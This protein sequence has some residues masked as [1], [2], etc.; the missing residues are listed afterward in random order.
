MTSQMQTET[1]TVWEQHRYGGP[2]SVTLARRPVPAP[3]PD[4][5][6][7]RVRATALNSGDVRIMRGQPYLVRAA[8]GLR[9]PRQPV[10]GM[11]VAG[12][13]VA[14]G[15]KAT[16]IEIGD[17]V[18]AEAPAGGALAAFVTV[19]AARV[20]PRP[21]SVEPA[22]AAT[23]PVAGGTA[24]QALDA[25]GVQA[26]ASVLVLGAS[27]GVGT[28]TVQLATQRGAEVWAFCGARS[29]G[30]V[31]NLGAVR[32]FDYRQTDLTSLRTGAFDAVIDIA[33]TAPLRVLRDLLAPGGT[34]VLVT[35]DGGRWLGPIPRML[36]ALLLSTRRHRIR[37]LA[38]V[39]KPETL[40]DLLGDTAEGRLRPLIERRFA[41]EEARDGLAHVD[42][43]HTVG[44][45]V[46]Q[47]D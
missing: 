23:L 16:G 5:V 33:G 3:K 41:F 30:I 46:V 36:R 6:L 37:F 47:L 13:V 21:Q 29:Q 35:G 44:K 22:V 17:E 24:A 26:G 32:S 18:V 38:A 11:D 4:E 20:V 31:E 19:P 10:R 7:I 45:V 25:A 15:A 12:A 8:F 14:K 42:A 39:A 34:V 43:G 9:R 27:G 40:R 28:F 1:M 2:Q